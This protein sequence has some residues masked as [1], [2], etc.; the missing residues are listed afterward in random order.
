MTDNWSEFLAQIFSCVCS[1]LLSIVH[2]FSISH[3]SKIWFIDLCSYTCDLCMIM[4]SLS[5]LTFVYVWKLCL[6][7]S[8]P[9]LQIYRLFKPRTKMLVSI[10]ECHC[11]NVHTRNYW[12]IIKVFITNFDKINPTYIYCCTN[13]LIYYQH[14]HLNMAIFCPRC[15]DRSW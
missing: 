9:F 4:M 6:V 7:K 11:L 10:D 5:S 1:N 13:Q 2:W 14:K 12:A 3:F 8:I 15:T